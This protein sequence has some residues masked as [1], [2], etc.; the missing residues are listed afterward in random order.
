[1]VGIFIWDAMFTRAGEKFE[2]LEDKGSPLRRADTL[3]GDGGGGDT[4]ESNVLRGGT[5]RT[6]EG[7]NSTGCT[8][9]GKE[10]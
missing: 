7:A 6:S 1:M 3:C 4:Y 9:Y 5:A 8:S 2:T 10:V